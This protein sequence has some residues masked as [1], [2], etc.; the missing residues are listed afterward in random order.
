MNDSPTNTAGMADTPALDLAGLT[1]D[2]RRPAFDVVEFLKRPLVA[3]LA[4]W[5]PETA[6]DSPLWFHHDG[7]DLWFISANRGDTF[8]DKV[9]EAPNAAVGIVDFDRPTGRFLHLGFRGIARPHPWD[10]DT[11]IALLSKYLGSNRAGWDPRF[12]DAPESRT[13]VFVR[14]TPRSFVA[15]DQ[16]FLLGGCTASAEPTQA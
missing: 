8:P 1:H 9:R 16:S 13:N 6:C 2:G 11:A 14:F 4:T 3:H 5:K 7:R 15:R 12:A 10:A